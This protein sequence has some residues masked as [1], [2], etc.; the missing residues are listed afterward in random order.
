[1]PINRLA[2]TPINRL[3]STEKEPGFISRVGEVIQKRTQTAEEI[4]DIGARGEQT[5]AEGV[6]QIAG[7]AAGGVFDIG[8]EGL[9]ALA[10]KFVERGIERGFATVMKTEPFRLIAEEIHNFVESHPRAAR[11]IG[12]AIN[13]TG[14]LGIP[15]VG[16]IRKELQSFKIVPP[17]QKAGE[18]GREALREVREVRIKRVQGKL[19]ESEL[20]LQH[21]Y[22]DVLN[23]TARQ[24]QLEQKFGKSTANFLVK[25]GIPLSSVKEGGRLKLD[26]RKAIEMLS[27]KAEMENVT[28]ERLLADSGKYVNFDAYINSIARNIK[29]TF[30]GNEQVIAATHLLKE[31]QAWKTQLISESITD[32]TGKMLIPVQNFNS[33]KKYFWNHTKGFNTPESI[34]QGDANFLAGHIA[35]NTIEEVVDDTTIRAFNRRLG[36]FSSSIKMLRK[37]NRSIIPGG[38]L[39]RYFARTIG[40]IA[41][42][43]GGPMGVIGGVITA[44]KLA[45]IFARPEFTTAMMKR[46]IES[47]RSKLGIKAD[48]IIREAEQ[49]IIRRAQERAGRLKIGGATPIGT[50]GRPIITPAPTTFEKGIKRVLRPIIY[51]PKEPFPDFLKLEAPLGTPTRPIITP[52]RAK[53]SQ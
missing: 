47:L 23:L 25:E 6:L 9:K 34:L 29:R 32:K 42:V 27:Q 48:D 19:L 11:N 33:V 17:L 21:K 4:S 44:D 16:V 22:N 35:K 51:I 8:F 39:G 12:A 49:I 24:T 53:K 10:L 20:R 52:Y 28:F 26:T 38:L 13:L 43:K 40:G 3:A 41:G 7:Q 31:L 14:L 36:D 37:R 50:S 18:L 30:H 5:F 45:E 15:K 2:A 1:M 46:T